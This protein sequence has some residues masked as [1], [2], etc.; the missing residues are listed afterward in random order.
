MPIYLLFIAPDSAKSDW[1]LIQDWKNMP[2]T[3]SIKKHFPNSFVKWMGIKIYASK[4][5]TMNTKVP[6]I[7]QRSYCICTLARAESKASH[8]VRSSV[9]DR[10]A[11]LWQ[12]TESKHC[13]NRLPGPLSHFDHS[14]VTHCHGSTR[15][16][17][18]HAPESNSRHVVHSHSFTMIYSLLLCVCVL[19]GHLN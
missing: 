3:T 19:A 11:N 4:Y 13:Y 2:P 6:V 17:K 15:Q 1:N 7:Y 14:H 16:L 8:S 5:T 18:L 12:Q 9:Y 10:E